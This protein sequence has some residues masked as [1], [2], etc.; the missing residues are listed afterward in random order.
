[1]TTATD[2][3]REFWRQMLRAGGATAIPRWTSAP[4]PG[5]ARHATMLHGSL[6]ATLYASG[7]SGSAL[8]QLADGM[9]ETAFT[10]WS[11]PGRGLLRP[12]A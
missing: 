11:F 5:T 9:D 2:T 4:R 10:D 8:S 12:F 7:K 3:G 1:M 6:V